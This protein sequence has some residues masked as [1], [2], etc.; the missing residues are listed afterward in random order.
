MI[1]FLIPIVAVA[2]A[3]LACTPMPARADFS[4]C[5]S[6]LQA[7]DVHQ[8]IALYSSCLKR[9]G[10]VA[11]DIAGAFNN[12]GVD[13]RRIGDTDAALQDFTSSIQY[14]PNWPTAYVNRSYIE[15][16]RGKCEEAL[17]DS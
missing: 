3:G 14:D 1:K 13:Y 17:A 11:T 12:R 15:A 9:G 16:S 8:Q 5:E 10:L 6:A 4:A 7:K 2:A